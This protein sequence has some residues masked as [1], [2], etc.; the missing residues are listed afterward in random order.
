VID[1]GQQLDRERVQ[2]HLLAQP[3]AEGFHSPSG[4]VAA[5][6]EAPIHRGL[7][8][9][10]GRP[11]DRGRGQGGAGDQPARRAR[12]DTGHQQEQQRSSRIAQAED[13]GEQPIDQGA[14][15]DPVDLVQPIP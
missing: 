10:P 5:P 7:D 1:H 4:V 8:A 3:R 2:V 13:C 12:A 6:V 15:D 11:E 14:V 9:A